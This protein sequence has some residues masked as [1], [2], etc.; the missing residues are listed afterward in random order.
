M[1]PRSEVVIRQ[2]DYLKGQVLLI[3]APNDQL[4]KSLPVEV[5]AS[6][7]TWN[8]ADHQGFLNAEIKSNFCVK[9]PANRYD[10]VVIFVPKSKW[11]KHFWE[12][13][14]QNQTFEDPRL[15]CKGRLRK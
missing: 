5:E 4:V 3:N 7:W 2:Q 14:E 12:F 6:V 13:S 11:E 9:F 1:D 15:H 8:F 10:Q